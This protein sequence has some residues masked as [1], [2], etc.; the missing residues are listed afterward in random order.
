MKIS[1]TCIIFAL[2]GWLAFSQTD[3][4]EMRSR[5]ASLKKYE[6]MSDRKNNDH[7]PSNF[8]MAPMPEVRTAVLDSVKVLSDSTAVVYTS[9]YCTRGR[10]HFPELSLTINVDSNGHELNEPIRQYPNPRV[11]SLWQPGADTVLNHPIFTKRHALDSIKDVIDRDYNF[12]LP[13][14]SIT[15]IGFD[16]GQGFSNENSVKRTK[17]R[18]KQRKNGFGWELMFMIL[19]PIICL[20]GI[21]R[22]TAAFHRG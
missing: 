12:N 16:N 13:S 21:S 19:T 22:L 15:F 7:V 6:R 14:D 4:I 1:L 9:N 11:G 17:H 20:I 8:G 5:N 18:R 10:R 3:I 2:S